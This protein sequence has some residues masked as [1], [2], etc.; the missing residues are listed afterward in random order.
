MSRKFTKHQMDD[1]MQIIVEAS[2]LLL[3]KSRDRSDELKQIGGSILIAKQGGADVRGLMQRL[4]DTC[5]VR[6]RE[7]EDGLVE[8]TGA[9]RRD[10]QFAALETPLGRS[11]MRVLETAKDMLGLADDT[12]D[13]ITAADLGK[14]R[15]RLDWLEPTEDV[16]DA[17]VK[18]DAIA[19]RLR[20][21]GSVRKE[22]VEAARTE[23]LDIL[24]GKE[25]GMHKSS[26]GGP[27]AETVLDGAE[28]DQFGNIKDPD[29]TLAAMRKAASAGAPVRKS[30]KA[31]ERLDALAKSRAE[32]DGV[33]FYEAY[34][35]VSADEPGLLA[36]AIAE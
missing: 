15:K 10:A 24:Q 35:R 19:D 12:Q 17:I 30:G 7:I 11:L 26:N 31:G 20:S 8:L 16:I 22:F 13:L 3:A 18:L 32:K 34:D 21:G 14:L 23:A 28:R 33:D 4:I 2:D 9:S 25:N 1:L 27:T 36:E 5:R 6:I 29:A